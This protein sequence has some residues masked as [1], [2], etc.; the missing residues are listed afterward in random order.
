MTARLPNPGGD[1]G[2]WGTILN[3]FLAVA[4]NPNGTLQATAIS[5]AGGVTTNQIGGANGVAGLDSSGIISTTQLG[6]GTASSSNFLRGDGIWAVPAGGGGGTLSSDTDVAIISPSSGQ[7][8][9]YNNSGNKWENEALPVATTAA[10]GLVRLDGDLSGTAS[11][12]TIVSTSL[13]N[14]LPINQGGTGST[15]QS[16]IDLT[17]NQTIA[18]TKTFSGEVSTASLQITGGTIANGKILTSDGSG[19]ATWQLAPSSNQQTVAKQTSSYTATT[20]DEVILADATSAAMTVTLPTASGNAC[21]YE[22]KKIDSTA[23]T[24]M[25]AT[26][27]GQTIDGGSTAIIKVQYA[28]ISIVSDGSNWY[29]L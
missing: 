9:T 11:S 22:I 8:L 20:S 24:V 4:H 1:D 2:D 13:S 25:I 18:G 16:F 15:T 29:I 3:S 26:N 27:G 14:P 23:H 5:D 17:T 28:S 6:G 7:V 21:L 12:P 10:A 19:N